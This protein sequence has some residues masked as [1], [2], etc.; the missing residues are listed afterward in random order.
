MLSHVSCC[1]PGT[2]GPALLSTG[3]SFIEN[4]AEQ[5]LVFSPQADCTCAGYVK[6]ILVSALLPL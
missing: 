4:I 5:S 1:V 6:T 3:C 2:I